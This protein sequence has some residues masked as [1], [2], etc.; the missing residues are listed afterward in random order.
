MKNLIE[1]D[2]QEHV[3]IIDGHNVIFRTI[4]ASQSEL[5]REHI[6]DPNFTYFKIYFLNSLKSLCQKFNPTRL[7]IAIDAKNGWRKKIYPEYKQQR[8]KARDD[9]KVD[10]EALFKILD[11]FLEELQN[12]FQNLEILK[13]DE[14]EGDDIIAVACQNISSRITIVSTDH[15]FYQLHTLKNVKQFNP[16]DKQI[17][18]PLNGKTSLEVKILGGDKNDNIPA[19][20][21]RCG[22]KTVA[23][24][25]SSNFLTNLYDDEYFK[26]EENL[27]AFKEKT[28]LSP[29]EVRKNLQRNT[30]LIDFKHIP[31]EIRTRILEKIQSPNIKKF[32]GRKFMNFIIRHELS[33]IIDRAGDFTSTLGK[34]NSEIK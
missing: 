27:K 3:L 2:I 8:K 33:P 19:I 15:D 23:S 25:M 24:L 26:L 34:L 21:P 16:K 28:K 5:D 10:F 12:A 31:T 11:T 32:D 1:E 14:A 7:I 30:Q 29:E 6:E 4:F 17:V 13:V 9:S 20:F 18:K 22:P